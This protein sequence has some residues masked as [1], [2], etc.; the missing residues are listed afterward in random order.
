MSQ[1]VGLA[2]VVPVAPVHGH[3]LERAAGEHFERSKVES[4]LRCAGK[5]SAAAHAG[6][7]SRRT[8]SC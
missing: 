7:W 3:G 2:H 4:V 5:S 8:D 1:T 6:R